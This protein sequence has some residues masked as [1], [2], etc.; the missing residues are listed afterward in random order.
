[1]IISKVHSSKHMCTFNLP[2]SSSH[3]QQK[4]PNKNHPLWSKHELPGYSVQPQ[5]ATQL[6]VEP[7][8][9]VRKFE[10]D[11]KSRLHGNDRYVN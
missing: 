10:P 7:T 9:A 2:L 1:M 4:R 8:F 3:Q 11:K 6:A 5:R